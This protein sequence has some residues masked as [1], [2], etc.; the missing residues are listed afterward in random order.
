[1]GIKHGFVKIVMRTTSFHSR[2]V[3]LSVSSL[4]FS[5]R[6]IKRTCVQYLA[7]GDVQKLRGWFIKVVGPCMGGGGNLTAPPCAIDC[8]AQSS[9]PRNTSQ[10]TIMDVSADD[11]VVLFKG[12]ALSPGEGAMHYVPLPIKINYYFGGGGGGGAA[13]ATS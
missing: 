11:F 6:V 13:E 8:C 7:M 5:P 2:I 12:H 3:L 10:E 9:R 4:G 1:M